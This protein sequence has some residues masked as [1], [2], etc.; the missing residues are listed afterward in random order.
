MLSH[1]LH[2]V[3]I[4]LGVNWLKYVNP[5]IDWCSGRV[6][7][8][9]AVHTALLEG[10]WVSSEHAIGTVKMLSNPAELKDVQNDHVRNS[11]SIL[12]TPK[13]WTLVNSRS[14]FLNGEVSEKKK[15]EKRESTGL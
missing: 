9:G 13:F 11:L 14:N 8:P 12:K 6:Y 7:L 2:D 1:L 3:D 10:K 4:M 15:K 5:I